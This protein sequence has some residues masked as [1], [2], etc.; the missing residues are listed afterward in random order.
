MMQIVSEM[1]CTMYAETRIY[2]LLVFNDEAKYA[3]G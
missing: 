1:R 3:S 2:A